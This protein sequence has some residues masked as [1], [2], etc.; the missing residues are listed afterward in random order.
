MKAE[1]SPL[2]VTDHL[3]S[4]A[5]LRLALLCSM[6]FVRD[7]LASAI[8]AHTGIE[9][10][11]S[12]TTTV[13]WQAIVEKEKPDVILVSVQP[14]DAGRLVTEILA[15]SRNS[16]V[17]ALG[18]HDD[19]DRE[20]LA[21]AMAGAPGF[22]SQ[23][24]RDREITGVIESVARGEFRYATTSAHIV[25][26]SLMR[27]AHQAAAPNVGILTRREQQV[28]ELLRELSNK[29]I[30]SRLGVEV[31]TVKSHVHSILTKLGVQRRRDAIRI[32]RATKS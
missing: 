19:D 29:E 8:V 22:V 30:A 17:V 3:E 23:L 12:L 14:S 15:A 27:A 6:R 4:T 20:V 9:V 5:R 18:Q 31:H 16:R 10:V 24:A 11:A 1:S 32:E 21:W 7:G 13:R 26:A 25:I 2:P 28:L